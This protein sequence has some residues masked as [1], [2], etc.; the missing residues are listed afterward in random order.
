MTTPKSIWSFAALL[1][2][3]A[4]TAC[5]GPSEIQGV[6]SFTNL[7]RDHKSGPLTYPQT[8][9]VGGNHSPTWQNCGVYDHQVALETAV[10][11]LEHGAV[12]I[13]YR[14]DLATADVQKLRDLLRGK[15]YTLLAPYQFGALSKP[16]VAVAWGVRLQLE[17]ADDPR[18]A[19][20]VTKY[21]NRPDGPEPAAP[22][23]GGTGNPSE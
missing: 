4:L 19:L 6:E 2:A 7:T 1:A 14:P 20:F 10:H 12:W 16:I 8:P 23:V 11:S 22:C 17:R 15:A 18:L 5:N 9:P 13:A 3:L 21:A